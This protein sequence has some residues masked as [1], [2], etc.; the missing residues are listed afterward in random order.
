MKVTLL[1]IVS[2]IVAYFVEYSLLTSQTVVGLLGFST[3]SLLEGKVWTLV[4]ALYVHASLLH[5]GAA[6][7]RTETPQ[8]SH[9]LGSRMWR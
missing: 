6:P 7:S 2:I 8:A 4:T 1:L 9:F 5:L 3:L